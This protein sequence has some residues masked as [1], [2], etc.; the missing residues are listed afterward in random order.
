M[1]RV[2]IITGKPKGKPRGKP[3]KSG[4]ASANPIGRPRRNAYQREIEMDARLFA[5]EHGIDAVKTQ[6]MVMSGLVVTKGVD[7]KPFKQNATPMAMLA[8]ANAILDRGYG[9]PPQALE[10]FGGDVRPEELEGTALQILRSKLAELERR[11]NEG[12]APL[13]LN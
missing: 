5:K 12:S 13:R 7:G 4:G 8:A 10:V 2:K 9:R 3:F 1:A 11:E 6:L